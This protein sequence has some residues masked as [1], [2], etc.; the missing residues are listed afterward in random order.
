MN[1]GGKLLKSGAELHEVQIP[2]TASLKIGIDLIG[3]M[4]KVLEGKRYSQSSLLHDE[5]C[6]G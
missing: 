6:G 3:L 4:N 2:N 5:V 1:S